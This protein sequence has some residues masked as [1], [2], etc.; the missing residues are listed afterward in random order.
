MN[1]KMTSTLKRREKALQDNCEM[2]ED[3]RPRCQS[4][5]SLAEQIVRFRI[6]IGELL[7]F[8]SAVGEKAHA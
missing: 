3:R 7:A 5:L 1:H 4:V 8:H 2:L 6:G